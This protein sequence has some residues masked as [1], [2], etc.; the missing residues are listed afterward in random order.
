MSFSVGR[1]GRVIEVQDSVVI[2]WDEIDSCPTLADAFIAGENAAYINRMGTAA[3]WDRISPGLWMLT[4]GGDNTG[5]MIS[6][7][8]Y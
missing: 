5:I 2:G 3:H 7:T 6:A 1:L 8:E 4:I